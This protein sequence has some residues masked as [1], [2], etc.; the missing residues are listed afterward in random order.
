MSQNPLSGGP[1]TSAPQA[2]VVATS[3]EASKPH[4]A[5]HGFR[6]KMI[7]RVVSAKAR[8]PR[9]TRN[10]APSRHGS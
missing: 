3:H 1:S 9:P 2:N 6:R 7:G 5:G 8:R 10:F 4:E